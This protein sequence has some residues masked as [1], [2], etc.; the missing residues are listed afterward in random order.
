MQLGLKEA[1]QKLL[2][3]FGSED[4]FDAS[5]TLLMRIKNDG[6]SDGD[7]DDDDPRS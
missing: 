4:R 5:P 7:A 3:R 1:I 2:R 6:D